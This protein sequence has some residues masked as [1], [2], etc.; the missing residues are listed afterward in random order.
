[1]DYSLIMLFRTAYD[2]IYKT[3]QINYETYLI[4]Y[5]IPYVVVHR[6]HNKIPRFLPKDVYHEFHY[7]R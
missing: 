6:A 2:N 1:M 4:T 7:S 5:W 3:M